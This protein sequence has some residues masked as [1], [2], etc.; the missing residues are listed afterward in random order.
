M[1]WFARLVIEVEKEDSN[2]V[3]EPPDKPNETLPDDLAMADDFDADDPAR[4]FIVQVLTTVK[5]K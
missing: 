4:E 2:L 3:S 1:L 5:S